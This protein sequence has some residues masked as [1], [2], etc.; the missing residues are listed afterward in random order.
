MLIGCTHYPNLSGRDLRGPANDVLLMQRTLVERFGFAEQNITILADA[1]QDQRRPTRRNIEREF[2]RLASV[3]GADDQVVILLSGHGSQQPSLDPFDPDNPKPDG[4]DEVFLPA[5]T[6]PSRE[7]NVAQAIRDGELRIWTRRIVERGAAVVVIVDACHAG[8]MLRGADDEVTRQV[9]ADELVPREALQQARARAAGFAT[10]H[11]PTGA[12]PAAGRLT[13]LGPRL[14][15]LYAALPEEP[16][17]EKRLPLDAADAKPYGL[18]TYAICQVLN[19]AVRPLT[20]RELL[21]RVRDEYFAWGRTY[22]TPLVEGEDQDCEVLGTRQW[23]GRSRFLLT[24]DATDNWRI[25]GGQ[26]HGLTEQSILA[27]HADDAEPGGADRIV[28]HV[29][30]TASRLL[31]ADVQPCAHAGVPARTPLPVG[32]RC[33]PVYLDYGPLRLRVG[34]DRRA[35]VLEARPPAFAAD[36][37]ERKLHRL[38][39][40]A[41]SLV[42][43][44][45]DASEARWLLRPERGRLYLVPVEEA[46][47]RGA[48]PI[49]PLFGPAPE[50]TWADWLRSSLARIARAQ[51]LRALAVG[52]ANELLRGDTDL[53]LDLDL[54]HLRDRDD[55]SGE[56]CRADGTVT[57]YDGDLVGFRV[58]NRSQTAVFVTLLFIDSGHGISAVYPGPGNVAERLPPDRAVLTRLRVSSKTTGLEHV[59]AIAVPAGR[60]PVDFT[61]LEQPTLERARSRSDGEAAFESPLGQLLQNALYAEGGVRGLGRSDVSRH[62]FRLLSWHT[63]PSPRPSSSR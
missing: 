34:V 11:G 61:C 17:F 3:A 36:D 55:R 24:R 13:G 8:T 21:Q 5:D 4:L 31:D 35:A 47:T 19:R 41:G 56:L 7:G 51:N 46:K 30:I 58:H 22:P 16:T 14:V 57:L 20:Y 40:E 6:A 42:Q 25:T 28:G 48:T 43:V 37:L 18:F 59:V 62:A 1:A 10:S 38:A 52:S 33:E 49:H 12:K 44:V 27:V 45:S 54:V 32:G 63:S 26:L 39:A 50:A 9:P 2:A 23:P 15:G 29:R 60:V 53:E